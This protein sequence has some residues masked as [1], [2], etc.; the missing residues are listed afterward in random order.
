MGGK[1]W[2]RRIQRL[3]PSICRPL[4]SG[5]GA[6]PPF[7]TRPPKNLGGRRQV[8]QH[9]GTRKHHAI[10]TGAVGLRHRRRGTATPRRAGIRRSP[11][12]CRP[13]MPS[14]HVLPP[15]KCRIPYPALCLSDG[16]TQRKGK[17]TVPQASWN[18]KKKMRP[19]SSCLRDRYKAFP[20][21]LGLCLRSGLTTAVRCH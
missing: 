7:H 17:H 8:G 16:V 5:C 2:A 4:R 15:D 18:S 11:I 6:G 9:L 21:N 19:L 10:P 12:P 3:A 14:S 13:G 1:S 20:Y